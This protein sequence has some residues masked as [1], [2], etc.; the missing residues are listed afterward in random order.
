MPVAT[1]DANK[2]KEIGGNGNAFDKHVL[3]TEMRTKSEY[4]RFC[5]YHLL[6]P[7]GGDVC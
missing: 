4:L 3:T 1:M 6:L 7:K 5:A 2:Q